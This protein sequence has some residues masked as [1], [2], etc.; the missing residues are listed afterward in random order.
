MNELA[1]QA[2]EAYFNEIRLARLAERCGQYETALEQLA[3]AHVLQQT[4][5]LRHAWVHLLMLRVGIR[6]RDWREAAGQVPRLVAAL[7]FSRIWV[8]RGNSGRARVSAFVPMD[9]PTDLRHLIP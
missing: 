7:I 9:V 1:T 8:P 6:R 3:R 4:S 5:A 2:K